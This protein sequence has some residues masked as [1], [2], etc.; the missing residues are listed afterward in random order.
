[1]IKKVVVVECKYE[2]VEFILPIF[3]REKTDGTQRLIRNLKSLN[4]YLEYKHFEMPTFQKILT[5][6]LPKCYMATIDLKVVYC[7]IKIDGG[8]TRFLKFL[9]NSVL[10]KWFFTRSMKCYSID[11][12]LSLAMIRMLRY[13]VAICIDEIIDT[14]QSFE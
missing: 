14:D 6:I 13:S 2:A 12:K 10:A 4:K 7:S 5:S 8:D 3:F 9:C 1:M 11:T